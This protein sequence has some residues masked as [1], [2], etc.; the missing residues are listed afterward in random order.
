MCATAPQVMALPIPTS[1][2][3]TII[4]NKVVLHQ[5]SVPEGLTSEQMVERERSHQSSAA[6]TNGTGRT[7]ASD[8]ESHADPQVTISEELACGLRT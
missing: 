1:A 3:N 7:N 5:I 8:L 6:S 2:I 4:E